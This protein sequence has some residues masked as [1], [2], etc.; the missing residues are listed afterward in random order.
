MK[1]KTINKVISK[2]INEWIESIDIE[3]I[4]EKIR[5]DTIVTGG[6]ITSLL[7]N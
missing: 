2:K 1:R 3:Y 5:K 4:R 6:C 7:L